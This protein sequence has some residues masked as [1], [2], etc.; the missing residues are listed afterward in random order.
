[1]KFLCNGIE[2]L[3]RL[4][5]LRFPIHVPQGFNEVPIV[6]QIQSPEAGSSTNISTHT[7]VSQP[8]A[9]SQKTAIDVLMGKRVAADN[10]VQPPLA[11]K[12]RK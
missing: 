3:K 7:E 8:H 6:I 12:K 2:L 4:Q 11:A 1:M 10:P 5:M 9:S